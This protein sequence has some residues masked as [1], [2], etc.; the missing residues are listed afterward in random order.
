MGLCSFTRFF[1]GLSTAVGVIECPSFTY[2]S[3]TFQGLLTIFFWCPLPTCVAELHLRFCVKTICLFSF[4]GGR[5]LGIDCKLLHFVGTSLHICYD[6]Y[7]VD[8]DKPN[9]C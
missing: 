5:F 6:Q 9:S 7:I 2:S 1:D 3:F 4:F 8:G